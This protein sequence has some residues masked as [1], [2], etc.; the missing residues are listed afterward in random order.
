MN[1]FY[2]V[3]N[4]RGTWDVYNGFGRLVQPNCARHYAI[5]VMDGDRWWSL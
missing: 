5:T 4:E 1:Y 2:A 3:R